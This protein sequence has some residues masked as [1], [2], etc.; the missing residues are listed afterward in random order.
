MNTTDTDNTISRSRRALGPDT[1]TPTG[2]RR[3]QA[4][5]QEPTLPRASGGS[6][7]PT[8]RT[9]KTAH[10]PRS[11]YEEWV[12]AAGRRVYVLLEEHNTYASSE[13]WWTSGW[14]GSAVDGERVQPKPAPTMV[15]SGGE[16]DA[17]S[18]DD[19]RA[20]RRIAAS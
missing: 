19:V 12:T 6:P 18:D 3:K 2:R 1:P 7:Q 15:C 17:R 10:Q 11:I 8:T 9:G 4:R 20:G 5:R 14:R 16:D 13:G